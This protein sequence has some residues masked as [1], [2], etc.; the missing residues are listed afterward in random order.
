[1][2]QIFVDVFSLIQVMDSLLISVLDSSCF[3]S[4]ETTTRVQMYAESLGEGRHGPL[5]DISGALR[6]LL[7]GLHDLTVV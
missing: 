4:A 3:H 6:V 5:L 1:M 2:K 7:Q